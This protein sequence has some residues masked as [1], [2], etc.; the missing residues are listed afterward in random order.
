MQS[1]HRANGGRKGEEEGAVSTSGLK[2]VKG[3]EII[4]HAWS[5]SRPITARELSICA[6][7]SRRSNKIMSVAAILLSVTLWLRVYTITD[8]CIQ[9]NFNV[10]HP[11]VYTDGDSR[12]HAR[13][14]KDKYRNYSESA[15]I[16][17]F[18]LVE[19]I[20]TQ[21]AACDR[22]RRK[23]LKKNSM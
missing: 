13:Q 11:R 17:L 18:T 22:R 15:Y 4:F 8:V 19:A 14:V 7:R 9:K 1:D 21:S 3:K 2:V 6:N 5:L 20:T 23:L 10:Q 16:H 12:F